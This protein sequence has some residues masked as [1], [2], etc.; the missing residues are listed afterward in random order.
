MQHHDAR[1]EVELISEPRLGRN[2]PPAVIE[3][4]L[5]ARR[6]SPP[7]GEALVHFQAGEDT[8]TFG[9]W[10]HVYLP[11]ARAREALAGFQV[12]SADVLDF[13]D[14]DISMSR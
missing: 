1:I 4:E 11:A 6:S 7:A 12:L 13:V 10:I 2:E 5:Q 14:Q 3:F 8:G 9:V